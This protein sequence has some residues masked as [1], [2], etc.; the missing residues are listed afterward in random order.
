M[1]KYAFLVTCALVVG[2][3]AVEFKHYF[4]QSVLE[5]TAILADGAIYDGDLR[6]GL[7]AGEGRIVWPNDNYYEGDFENGLFHGQG[8][9]HTA[10]FLYEGEFELGS[11]IGEGMIRYKNGDR[12]EGRVSFALPNG[13]GV[14]TMAAGQVY[15]GDFENGLYH[16]TGEFVQ[17]NGRTKKSYLGDFEQGLF[18]G[19]GV[20]TV[21]EIQQDSKVDINSDSDDFDNADIASET[22]FSGQFVKGVLSGDGVWIDGDKRYE[23]AFVN[24]LFQGEGVYSDAQGTYNGSFVN[25]VFEGKGVYLGADGDHYDGEFKSGNYHGK[26]TLTL[27]TG[28]TYIG[29]FQSGRKHGEGQLTYAE[30]LD[31]INS[32]VGG[33]DNGRL[34]KANHPHLVVDDEAL[35]E[36]ALYHQP[37]RLSAEL[38]PIVEEDPDKIE[39]YFVGIAGD[40]QQG[41]F[42]REVGFVKD[43]FDEHYGTHNK[44]V[45]LIN[46][47]LSY[48]TKPL[49]TTTSI[50]QTL[51]AVA[52]KMDAEND[53]LFV[54]LTSH[55]SKDFS[56]HLAQ[57]GLSLEPLTADALGSMLAS[58]PV[59]HKV[60]VIS[61]CFSGGFVSPIKDDSM[62]VITASEVD[63]TSFGCSD[64]A[65]MTYFGEAFFK[66]A[67][68]QPTYLTSTF[69]SAFDRARD[70]VRGR[71]AKEGFENS[72][73][74]IF[75]SK[76][77][78]AQLGLWREQ[79][80][81]DAEAEQAA[82]LLL[83]I[84][85]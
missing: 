59:R 39:L 69:E 13:K 37:E 38:A 14:L 40:G 17:I 4:S 34:I 33:W 82:Q 45:S 5:P 3:L 7:L 85:N 31:G 32:V 63:K 64:L 53:I 6:K 19:Q 44:S 75:K 2:G 54:Y 52:E 11:A 56:L 10:E 43:V 60:V 57:P 84:E 80:Q 51:M 9:L 79:L 68:S 70:I 71:E 23:G 16:G 48:Q 27:A 61:A 66:D 58:L 30:T 28:E 78:V 49:A 20:Y 81:A 76:A 77:I 15:T 46:S 25:G 24:W 26:G 41:V 47:P 18:H 36:Y 65:K 72:N 50:E 22:I 42:R 83:D 73:P 21:L 74:L 67:L 29:G 35:V 55:G 62:M 1:L 12:Y 8:I